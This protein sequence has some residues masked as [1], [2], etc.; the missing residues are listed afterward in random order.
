MVFWVTCVVWQ[1]LRRVVKKIHLRRK[2]AR[3]AADKIIVLLIS[4]VA[5]SVLISWGGKKCLAVNLTTGQSCQM[6]CFQTKNPNLGKLWRAMEDVG[7][8]YGHSV[9]FTVSCFIL[10]I[11]GIVMVIWHI[12]PRFGILYQEKSGNPGQQGRVAT[13]VI[14]IAMDAV[15]ARCRF[16]CSH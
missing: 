2:K 4:F 3:S 14:R 8:F 6:V 11:F 1:I 9:H 10:W 15:V 12:F 13:D 7:I 5:P 16:A